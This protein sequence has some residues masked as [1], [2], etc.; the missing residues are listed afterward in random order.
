[1]Q[2]INTSFNCILE[3]SKLCC[4]EIKAKVC[5]CNP[6]NYHHRPASSVFWQLCCSIEVFFFFCFI[7]L[8]THSYLFGF[9]SVDDSWCRHTLFGCSLCLKLCHCRQV[10]LGS[11][12]K[13]RFLEWTT[14]S[15]AWGSS[16]TWKKA[17]CCWRV[18]PMTVCLNA[19]RATTP[20]HHGWG[21]TYCLFFREGK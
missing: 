12:E 4:N 19:T 7:F 5:N 21:C 17:D 1:M 2:C 14:I 20:Q 13:G 3:E 11:P 16:V 6:V 8:I 10:P 9:C 18:A 15:S